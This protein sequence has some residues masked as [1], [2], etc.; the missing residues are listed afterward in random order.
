MRIKRDYG[1]IMRNFFGWAASRFKPFTVHT[2]AIFVD[3]VWRKIQEHMKTGDVS[4][5][6]VMTPAN[7]DLY[8]S[9]FNI[10]MSKQQLSRIMK[11]RYKEMLKH[12]QRLE[13]HTHLC[14]TMR[15]M[16]YK[17]Q[18]RIIGESIDWMKKE[19]GV[20]PKEFVA[21]WWSYNDDT[22][23]VLKKFGLKMISPRDY[24]YGH[25]YEWII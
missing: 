1:A 8:K 17:E 19:L 3:E 12:G 13:L 15:L 2:E 9:S 14:L 4:K 24:D 22:L 11:V 20:S 18:E 7:Y 10:K 6:Y 21:G 16:S 5:W 25:D 23:K